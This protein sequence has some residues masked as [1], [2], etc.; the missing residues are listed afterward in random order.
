MI[1]PYKDN[2]GSRGALQFRCLQPS[3]TLESAAVETYMI[4]KDMTYTEILIGLCE[5]IERILDVVD[6]LRDSFAQC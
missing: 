2:E 1:G 6:A 5:H 4:E 3:P